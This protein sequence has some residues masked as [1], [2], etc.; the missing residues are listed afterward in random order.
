MKNKKNL[1]KVSEFWRDWIEKNVL[2]FVYRSML[3]QT[4]MSINSFFK[5]REK[6]SFKSGK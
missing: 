1:I 4:D 3:Y 2:T 5:K 6:G